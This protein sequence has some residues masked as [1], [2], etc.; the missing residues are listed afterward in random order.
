[1]PLPVLARSPGKL[2]RKEA[3][4]HQLWAALRQLWPICSMPD[5]AAGI[6]L[7]YCLQNSTLFPYT[8]HAG[9]PIRP[10]FCMPSPV[11]SHFI[12]IFLVLQGE[13]L[14]EARAAFARE[15]GARRRLHNT[16][17]EL[18]GNIRVF[19]RVRPDAG[20]P[21]GVLHA[22]DGHRVL[23]TTAGATKARVLCIYIYVMCTA[24]SH[25]MGRKLAASAG[26]R[27]HATP[28]LQLCS[29]S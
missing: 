1:M 6:F 8:R 11:F 17:Q 4:S 21:G 22:E 18:R 23:A 7:Q 9:P 14:A 28:W 3:H 2:C 24:F 10:V 27:T 5:G 25:G 19:V 20:A 29:R 26:G 13:E 15:S 12:L 16:V